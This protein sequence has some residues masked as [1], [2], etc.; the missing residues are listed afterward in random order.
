MQWCT[1]LPDNTVVT[2][3]RPG[4]LRVLFLFCFVSRLFRVW[5]IILYCKSKMTT[6]NEEPCKARE[7]FKHAC[8]GD[9]TDYTVE[10]YS[11]PYFHL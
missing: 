11:D 6:S 2:G 1:A 8:G 3:S 10:V 9:V 5:V 4:V 7:A